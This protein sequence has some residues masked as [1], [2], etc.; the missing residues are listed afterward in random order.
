[1]SAG[2]D[3][4]GDVDPRGGADAPV[5]WHPDAGGAGDLGRSTPGPLTVDWG[6]VDLTSLAAT[7][8]RVTVGL[9]ELTERGAL[10]TR[11]L[12][13]LLGM[14]DDD[15]HVTTWENEGGALAPPAR[16]ET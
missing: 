1:M 16:K 10:L 12:D 11:G 13:Q 5:V 14:R 9:H 15:D 7:L 4:D 2:D 8:H 3:G 6:D